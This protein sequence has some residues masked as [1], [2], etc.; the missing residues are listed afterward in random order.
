MPAPL[1]LETGRMSEAEF[2]GAVGAQLTEQLGRTIDM[3]GFGERYFASLKPSRVVRY[4]VPG[5]LGFNFMLYDVL[6]GGASRS[7]RSDT[8]GKTHGLSLLRM[9]VELPDET[10]L[11]RRSPRAA[12]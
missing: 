11:S 8:Q 7:L 5:V 9:W 10:V 3:A 2:L 4:E 1:E 12:C 6:A